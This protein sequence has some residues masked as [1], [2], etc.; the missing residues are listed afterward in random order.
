M[1]MK[2][3]Y[4]LYNLCMLFG[5]ICFSRTGYDNELLPY[6]TTGMTIQISIGDGQNFTRA[7]S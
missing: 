5:C 4:V 7:Q 3:R 2:V 1:R 6:A